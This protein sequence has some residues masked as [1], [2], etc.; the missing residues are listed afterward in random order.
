MGRLVP[1]VEA[2]ICGASQ[3]Q[4]AMLRYPKYPANRVR[5]LRPARIYARPQ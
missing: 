4:R 2:A 5:G 3:N 1:K